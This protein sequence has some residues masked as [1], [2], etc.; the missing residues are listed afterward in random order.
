MR[1]D[2]K[3]SLGSQPTIGMLMLSFPNG[4]EA[5]AYEKVIGPLEINGN[6]CSGLGKYLPYK[7]SWDR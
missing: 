2:I 6:R 1:L 3:G 4:S 7:G 5:P